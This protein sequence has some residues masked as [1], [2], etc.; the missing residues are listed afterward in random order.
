MSEIIKTDAIVLSKMDYGDSSKI[1][2]LYTKDYGK[3]TAIIKGARSSN[4]KIG[5]IVDLLNN[6]QIVLYNK[7]SR[8]VQLITQADLISHYTLIKNDLIKY[9]YA[10]IILELVHSLIPSAEKNEKIFR[11]IVKIL[12]LIEKSDEQAGVLLLKFILFFIKEIGFELQLENCTYCEKEPNSSKSYYFNFE[13]GIMCDDC[14][15][16]HLVAFTFSQELFNLFLCLRNRKI[17]AKFSDKLFDNALFFLEKY[18][19][20]HIPEFKGISSIHIY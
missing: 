4:S 19:K 11:G 8:E 9:K 10:S 14:A 2:S 3:I 1:V 13:K 16:D 5:R 12:D 18:I 20:Y 17:D 15:K 7:D 6:V